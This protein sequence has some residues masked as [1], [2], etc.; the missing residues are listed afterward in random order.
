MCPEQKAS[1]AVLRPVALL[2]A[3]LCCV[4]PASSQQFPN[5]RA[6]SPNRT[7]A[8]YN[9]LQPKF[10]GIWEPVSFNADVK[11]FDVFFATADE[12]WVAGG[13]TE[14]R[15]GILLHTTDG[16]SHWDVVYGDPQSSDRAVH[17]LR[18]LDSTHGWAI[19]DTGS[20]SRLLHTRDGL[21]WMLAGTI[22]EHTVDY[23]FTSELTGVAVRSGHLLQ[24]VDG[25][26]N[27]RQAGECV[28]TAQVQGLARNLGC[29]WTRLQFVTPTVAYAVGFN[30][31]ARNL[32]FLARTV[33][34][35][36]SWTLSTGEVTDIPQDAF[37]LDATTGYVRVGAP[38]TGQIFKTTDGGQSWTGMAASPGAR[39]QF[40][41]PE[42][43]WAVLYN[44]V[45][46][47]TDSGSRWN[48]RQY[49]FPARLNAFS[50]P[51]RDR[52][53]VVGEHGMI[54]RYRIVPEEYSAAG[55]IPAPL[56]SGI[57]SPLETQMQQL[58]LQVQ[59]L[60]KDAGAPASGFAQDT[61][62]AN[63][64]TAGAVS[65]STASWSNGSSGDASSGSFPGSSSAGSLIAAGMP[66]S[67]PGCAA[68]GGGL[69]SGMTNGPQSAMN[70]AARSATSF[71]S[72][73]FAQNT[74]GAADPSDSTQTAGSGGFVQDTNTASTTVASV[75]ETVPQFVSKYRNLNL[76][77]TGFQVA[78]RMP[79]TAQ[80]L[81]QSFRALKNIRN[82]QATLAAVANI[83]EQTTGLMQMVRVAFQ[84]P[85]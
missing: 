42:V 47:T 27:W 55:M 64:G 83:Q 29:E 30:R 82:P 22:P 8:A 16:G 14:L 84:R 61:G 3:A 25:G 44:K 37:F 28:V 67:I 52:G 58:E 19:Q 79:A 56:L 76:L 50:L 85:R 69:V 26:R 32:V 73:G 62:S 13:T 78:T 74:T 4:Y 36:A 5:K 51:R 60:A 72:G 63:A 45:S 39:I 48:S 35:G 31:Q 68:V 54:Y 57:D 43:G 65:A 80:C 20:A 2:L 34:G 23:M 81:A 77:L 7:S 71:D 70:S 59:R 66:A 6:S 53:Y 40:A 75:S 41:D 24:T 18:F 21:N 17:H 11:L 1:W 9:Q 46:F 10:K 12:G 38:D 49:P 33:D 15:G